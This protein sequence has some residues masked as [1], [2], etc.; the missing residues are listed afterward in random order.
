MIYLWMIWIFQYGLIRFNFKLGGITLIS[1]VMDKYRAFSIPAKAAIWFTICNL[2]IKGI[3]FITVPIFTRLMPDTEYGILS[4]YMSY[5]QLILI[6]ATWEIQMGA[7]QKGLFN[8]KGEE[9][10]FTSAAQALVNMITISFFIIIFLLNRY[11]Q[12]ITGLSIDILILMFLYLLVQPSYNCWLVRQRT[13]YRYKLTV[14]VTLSY[15]VLIV[16]IP[17]IGIILIGGFAKVKYGLTIFCSTLFCL[18]FYLPNANYWKVLKCWDK[19]KKYWKFLLEFE[20]PL[21]LHSLSYL[22]LSQADRVMIGNL[23]GS[24]QA[25]YYSVAY[26]I[27]NVVSILQN[28]INQSL[29][30]WR[31]EMLEKKNYEQIRKV[32][33]YLLGAIGIFILIFILIAPEIMNI[34]FTENYNESKWCIPP[35]SVGVYFMFLYTIFVNIESYFEKTR[36]VMYVSVVCGIINIILNSICIQLFGYIACGYTTMIS[37]ILFALGHYYF[38]SK[39][40]NEE[41]IDEQI[42]DVRM[43]VIIS[44]IVIIFSIVIT[45][46]YPLPIIRYGIFVGVIFCIMWNLNRIR[47]ILQ[48][49]KM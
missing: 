38:T 49:L 1:A 37:Y 11:V 9:K 39:I 4:I 13:T 40:L 46:L 12:K 35:I 47:I 41:N 32:T 42:V 23:V 15:T 33:N 34:L 44:T 14:I 30:P 6:L 16:V 25:A 45:F 20:A 28:S 27:A 36:F 19:V 43:I 22:I 18:F 5:E 3:S 10:I 7:Y 17:L 2:I 31:Y 24:A 29:L 21:V 8:Y 48:K 26:S